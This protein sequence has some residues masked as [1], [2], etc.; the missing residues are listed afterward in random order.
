MENKVLEESNLRR[1]Q[2]MASFR[3]VLIHA[4]DKVDPEVVFGIFRT[5]LD[6]FSLFV[7]DI[8]ALVHRTSSNR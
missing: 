3:N 4:Y 2:D 5:R 8:K 6:D 1:F 7:N